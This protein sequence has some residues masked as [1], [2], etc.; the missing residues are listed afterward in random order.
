MY[1]RCGYIEIVQE[2]ADK[3]MKAA[4]EEIKTMPHYTSDGEVT[5]F[6]WSVFN[7]YCVLSSGLLLMLGMTQQLMPIILQFHASQGGLCETC[8]LLQCNSP[9]G[10]AQYPQDFRYM[11]PLS[12]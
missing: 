12:N 3:S 6:F 10:C 8:L 1:N 11:H 4:V 2:L 5:S 7:K 9:Y